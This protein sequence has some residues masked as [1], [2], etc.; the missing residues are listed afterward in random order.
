MLMKSLIRFVLT[1]TAALLVVSPSM[2]AA[3]PV[4]GT[5]A[6]S[7][8]DEA[9]Q[10]ISGVLVDVWTWYTGNETRTDK[11][12]HFQLKGLRDDRNVEVRFSKV[13]LSPVYIRSQ[14]TSVDDLKITM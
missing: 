11:D 6:G 2:V 9:G 1:L 5:I 10:P 14:P 7:V 8:T 3:D 12:G 4:P 13:G